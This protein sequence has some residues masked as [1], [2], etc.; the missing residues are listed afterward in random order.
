MNKRNNFKPVHVGE[1]G[2]QRLDLIAAHR[3]GGQR[4]E[5]VQVVRQLDEL[6]LS[7]RVICK[8]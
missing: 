4:P 5:G 3:E 7:V 2:W 1:T 6:I 8:Q